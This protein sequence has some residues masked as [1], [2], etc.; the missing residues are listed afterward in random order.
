MLALLFCLQLPAAEHRPKL[1][2][3]PPPNVLLIVVDDVGVDLVGCYAERYPT[4][5]LQPCT[6]NID[7]LA[8]T[9]VRF[10]NAWSNPVCSPT[11]AQ[12]LTGKRAS[13][14]GVGTITTRPP[15]FPGN[16]GLQ[17]WEDTLASMLPN[18]GSKALGKWHVSDPLQDGTS[19]AHP[20]ALGFSRYAGSLYGLDPDYDDWTKCLSPPGVLLP[21]YANY[22]TADTAADAL[23]ELAS[24]SE[25][26]LL[27]VGF[28]APHLPFHCPEDMGFSTGDCQSGN[29]PLPWCQDCNH[30]IS[31]PLCAAVGTAA[32]Q[33]RAMMHA[34]DSKIGELLSAID[35]QDTAVIL[36]SDNGTAGPAV[37]PPFVQSQ[38][39][40]SLFQGGIHVPLIARAPGCTPSVRHELVSATDIFAT[41]ADLAGVAPPPDPQRDSV[42]FHPLLFAGGGGAVRQHVFS[43][44]FT[45][46]FVPDQG[47]PPASFVAKAHHRAIR[48]ATHKLIEMRGWDYQSNACEMGLRFY[49]LADAPLQDPAFGPDPFEQDDLMLSQPSWTPE[50]QAAFAELVHE[51]SVNYLRLPVA[52]P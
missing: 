26:W 4:L 5:A 29:C 47:Q 15:W 52:C 49:R 1:P 35:P 16:H 34:L 17:P 40:G 33:T 9:G 39:K 7:Q 22:A 3:P 23:V 36:I 20:L 8:A 42:S 32:C 27:Y 2:A 45:L 25:P 50:D 51:L 21:H 46:N 13:H 18:Y 44:F 10:T 31:T 11:R 37:V 24:L 41:L 19:F 28:N 14:T 30:L 48:N 12:I 6:P 38:S 43:E